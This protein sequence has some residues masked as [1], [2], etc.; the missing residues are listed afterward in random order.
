MGS[1]KAGTAIFA[2][3]VLGV[4]VVVV[5]VVV[6]VVVVVGSDQTLE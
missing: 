2:F 6:E 5:E 4:V 3:G 1:H